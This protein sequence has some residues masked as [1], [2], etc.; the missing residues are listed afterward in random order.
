[1]HFS[2]EDCLKKIKVFQAFCKEKN[3]STQDRYSCMEDLQREIARKKGAYSEDTRLSYLTII[4]YCLIAPD[5]FFKKEVALES[6]SKK[7][8]IKIDKFLRCAI[9]FYM[10][11]NFS[12]YYSG[13]IDL[14]IDHI[15]NAIKKNDEQSS[16]NKI[17]DCTN[18]KLEITKVLKKRRIELDLPENAYKNTLYKAFDG[19]SKLYED[20]V[21]LCFLPYF[22]FF[23]FGKCEGY[24]PKEKAISAFTVIQ[25][26]KKSATWNIRFSP[27]IS[28]NITKLKNCISLYD[29]IRQVVLDYFKRKK[30]TTIGYE[31]FLSLFQLISV[32][33]YELHESHINNQYLFLPS[34]DLPVEM[35]NKNIVSNSLGFIERSG[36][37]LFL[38]TFNREPLLN[39]LSDLFGLS[40]IECLKLHADFEKL[41]TLSIRTQ[42]AKSTAIISKILGEYSDKL[43]TFNNQ[44][45]LSEVL[46]AIISVFNPREFYKMKS[47]FEN[48]KIVEAINYLTCFFYDADEL[49]FDAI[50]QEEESTEDVETMKY[51]TVADD[52]PAEK[53]KNETSR[54]WREVLSQ[55][56]YYEDG[57]FNGINYF[58][59]NELLVRA[60]FS[61]HHDLIQAK[62]D[63]LNLYNLSISTFN[64]GMPALYRFREPLGIAATSYRRFHLAAASW[65][66]LDFGFQKYEPEVDFN[67]MASLWSYQHPEEAITN[68]SILEYL[69]NNEEA[70][71]S[72]YNTFAPVSKDKRLYA[73]ISDKFDYDLD[74]QIM[75]PKLKA[76]IRSA[77]KGQSASAYREELV[78]QLRE[79]LKQRKALLIKTLRKEKSPAPLNLTDF[80][81]YLLIYRIVVLVNENMCR[82]ASELIKNLVPKI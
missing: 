71:K 57:Q 27:L 66:G 37:S 69:F 51:Y 26:Q 74:A 22:L 59:P 50:C 60:L 18:M 14:Y 77:P 80:H 10:E 24:F 82:T 79:E 12:R 43:F 55:C 61:E 41:Y 15:R 36:S 42:N 48:T 40:E 78:N 46:K 68:N 11:Y 47:V 16:I 17:E 62:K 25:I 20:P 3:L 67:V 29:Q 1:M 53:Y 31:V 44:Y 32:P 13:V 23:E 5:E 81:Y 76:Y 8:H 64:Y 9:D 45:Q 6:I 33:E 30:I 28:S 70:L 39:N 65:T 2:R 73:Y 72:I 19:I 35:V 56:C 75:N 4:Y 58:D 7:K 63:E 49:S 52:K 38:P 21:F 34:I 54:N